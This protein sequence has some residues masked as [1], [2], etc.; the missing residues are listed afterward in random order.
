MTSDRLSISHHSDPI[1]DRCDLF[2]AMRDVENPHAILSQ[3]ADK[4]EKM[5]HLTIC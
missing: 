5:V 3:P 4:L 2:Q 1:R